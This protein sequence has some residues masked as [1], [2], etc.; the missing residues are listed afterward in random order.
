MDDEST[1]IERKF[2][3]LKEKVEKKLYNIEDQIIGMQLSN[4]SGNNLSGKAVT[5]ESSL[6]VNIL[7]NRI[8]ELE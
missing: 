4:V 3:N 6:C 7:K 2:N 5:S 8:L 1:L